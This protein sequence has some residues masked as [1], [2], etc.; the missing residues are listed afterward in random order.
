MKSKLLTLLWMCCFFM[1]VACGG[2]DPL[3]DPDPVPPYGSRTILIYLAANNSLS[4]L[5]N[6]DFAEMKEGVA[7]LNNSNI[8]LLVYIDTGSSPRLVELQKKNGEVVEKVIKSYDSKRNS[9]GVTETKEVFNEVFSNKEYKAESYGL[10]YWSHGD[11]WI[12]NPLPSTRWV[13]QDTG[14]GTYYMNIS[15]LVSIM[16]DMPHFDFILFD[17]CFMQSIEVAYALRAYTD[18]YIGSP[19]EIP[20]PGARYDILVPEMFADGDVALKAAAAYYTPYEEKYNGGKG[21]S[22]IN[23]TGGVSVGVLKSSELER[24]AS[25]TKQVL[26]GPAD[27]SELLKVYDYDKRTSYYGHVG[28]YDMVDMMRLLTDDSGFT[29]WKKVY[30]VALPYWATT[31]MNFSGFIY[32]MFSMEGTHGVSHYVPSSNSAATAAYRSTDWYKDAGL[33]KLGW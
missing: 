24:L 3:P 8:H 22:N 9:V 15:D 14:N 29:A 30:D 13:G 33:S 26:S 32:N 18:Y 12:P 6:V 2:D 10:V 5:A 16:K 7:K 19:T 27:N 17:A 25:V 1:F 21:N 23:W 31:P 28:Y 4:D 11:G 20:G